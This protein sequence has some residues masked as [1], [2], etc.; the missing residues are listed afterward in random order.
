MAGCDE[1]VPEVI[2]PRTHAALVLAAAALQ[3]PPGPNRSGL[4]RL[5]CELATGHPLMNLRRERKY[6]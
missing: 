1:R 4:A 2:D 6:G 3:A 5:A